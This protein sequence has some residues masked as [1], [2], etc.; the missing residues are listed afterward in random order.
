[1]L[2]GCKGVS[3]FDIARVGVGLAD[4]LQSTLN[5]QS[6]TL[7]VH[8]SLRI[9]HLVLFL[10]LIQA[11][12]AARSLHTLLQP[13]PVY[14]RLL[15]HAIVKLILVPLEGG[16]YAGCIYLRWEENGEDT[17]SAGAMGV[18][19]LLLLI[20]E[21]YCA[22]GLYSGYKQAGIGALTPREHVE[23]QVAAPLKET[24]GLPYAPKQPPAQVQFDIPV[25]DYT[26][27]QEEPQGSS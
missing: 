25:F 17:G 11:F 5:S 4:L 18:G 15:I 24:I 1:M 26:S 10:L 23:L 12:C 16:L 7:L 3:L 6:P 27:Y 19:V 20:V 14:F 22:L 13:D 21:I 9:S 2:L 8:C